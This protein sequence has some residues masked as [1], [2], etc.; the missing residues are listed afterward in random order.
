MTARRQSSWVG[1]AGVAVAAILWIASRVCQCGGE[2]SNREPSPPCPTSKLSTLSSEDFATRLN[3]QKDFVENDLTAKPDFSHLRLTADQ[4]RQMQK[5]QLD[6]EKGN[7][8]PPMSRANLAFSALESLDLSGLN[9]RNADL[10]CASLAR[11]NRKGASFEDAD[12]RWRNTPRSCQRRRA[13]FRRAH[14]SGAD[15]SRSRLKVSHFDGAKSLN[16]AS[17]ALADVTDATFA[18]ADLTRAGWSPISN[19]VVATI[20]NAKGLELLV[21]VPLEEHEEPSRSR[22]LGLLCMALRT[23]GEDEAKKRSH[24]SL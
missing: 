2:Y 1:G 23:Q 11:A 5:L 6:A 21:P 12:P 19:P 14:M 18:A 17:F 10:T 22:G 3:Q 4:V 13:S 7:Q 20:A 24:Q 15:F 8:Q 16:G 9:F